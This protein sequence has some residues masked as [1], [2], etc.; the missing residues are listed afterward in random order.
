MPALRSLQKEKEA[1]HLERNGERLLRFMQVGV[2]GMYDYQVADCSS[3][4]A[5][6]K[7]FKFVDMM[8]NIS[9]LGLAAATSYKRGPSLRTLTRES[10]IILRQRGRQPIVRPQDYRGRALP[11]LSEQMNWV[12][13][14]ELL[15]AA[16]LGP[17]GISFASERQGSCALI[18]GG[19]FDQGLD[20]VFIG[21]II[22]TRP[23]GLCQ[24]CSLEDV[25]NWSSWY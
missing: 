12:F 14:K 18:Q 3:T 9:Y 10:T 2:G 22:V 21:E 11:A 25:Q 24:V 7:R 15:W 4:R 16:R 8:L 5:A 1:V 17:L 6:Q 19:F 23:D 20:E 13:Q